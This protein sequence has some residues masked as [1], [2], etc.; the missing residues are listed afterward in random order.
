VPGN[1]PPIDQLIPQRQAFGER[2]FK[3]DHAVFSLGIMNGSPAPLHTPDAP[4]HPWLESR[5]QPFR[6]REAAPF[7]A[8]DSLYLTYYLIE[9]P[10][11][12][13]R[14][15]LRMIPFSSPMYLFN[16]RPTDNL[17]DNLY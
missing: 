7:G 3:D 1:V 16:R 6:F 2:L 13:F 8:R 11:T 9:I 15:E 17:Y 5:P 4:R 10:E 14:L 12:H